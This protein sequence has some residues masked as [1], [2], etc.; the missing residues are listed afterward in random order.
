MFTVL[1]KL[2][3]ADLIEHD[4]LEAVRKQV[5]KLIVRGLGTTLH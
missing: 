4:S 1:I 2:P 5:R 3:A